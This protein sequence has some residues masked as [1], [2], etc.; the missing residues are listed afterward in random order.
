MWWRKLNRKVLKAI[1]DAVAAKQPS[2]NARATPCFFCSKWDF[3][4]NMEETKVFCKGPYGHFYRTVICH[5][6]CRRMDEGK[7]LCATCGKGEVSLDEQED[8][9][10]EV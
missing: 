10:T 9:K 1:N 3:V 7:M 2:K 8:D 6:E 5:A 4:G